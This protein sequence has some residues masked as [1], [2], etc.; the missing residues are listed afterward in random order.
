MIIE[1]IYV[2]ASGVIWTVALTIGSL[3]F[4]LVLGVPLCIMRLSRFAI[5]RQTGAIVI[6]LMQSIPYILMLFLIYFGIGSGYLNL[7]PFQ[8]A[9]IGFGLVT[10]ANVAEIYR[11]ALKAIHPGQWEAIAALNMP[12]RSSFRDIIAPQLLRIA[13]P[14]I[15]TYTIGLMKESALASTIGVS[16]IAFYAHQEA[17]RTFKGLE[18]FAIAGLLYMALSIPI[19]GLARYSDAKLQGRIAR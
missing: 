10:G 14:S 6:L 16:D 18:V 12:A 5:I 7:T 1:T 19:A 13:L 11:G 2:V 3:S 4:G 9:V 8:A 17:E 15:A